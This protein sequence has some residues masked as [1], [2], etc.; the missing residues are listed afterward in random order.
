MAAPV[1]IFNT[2]VN[3]AS[4]L[5]NRFLPAFPVSM[6]AMPLQILAGFALIGGMLSSPALRG[7]AAEFLR[8]LGG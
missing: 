3:A 1:A 8:S 4:G 6:L 7:V 5:A 2:A